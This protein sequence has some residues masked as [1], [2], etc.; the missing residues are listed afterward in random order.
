VLPLLD[1]IIVAAGT[2]EFSRLLGA[3]VDI[4]NLTR[5]L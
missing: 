3:E 5:M 1:F 4:R 2:R